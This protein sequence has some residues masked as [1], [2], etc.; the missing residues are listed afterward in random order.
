MESYQDKAITFEQLTMY[1]EDLSRVYRLEKDKRTQL[2]NSHKQLVSY[3]NDLTS[4]INE[5]KTTNK[6]LRDSYLET[7]Y[8]LVLA[9]EFKDEDTGDHI[10]RISRYSFLLTENLNKHNEIID[11]IFYASQMHDIGKIGIPDHILTKNTK[12]TYEEFEKMKE[13]TIVGANILSNS[14]SS[15]L[16][17]A[18]DIALTH[19]EKWDGSGYPHGLRGNEIP[20]SGRIICLVD[21]FDALTSKRPYKNPY[22]PEVVFN[23]LKRERGRQFDPDLLDIFFENIEEIDLIRKEFSQEKKYDYSD[24]KL[25]QRDEDL[26]I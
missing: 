12:L 14:K 7:I 13:H 11:N 3:A 6:E 8:R 15:I 22:P 24:F 5:L 16:Q 2:E 1:A 21:V 10:A 9:A 23:I 20:I 25:S 17:L 26:E 18:H 4:T 19:H